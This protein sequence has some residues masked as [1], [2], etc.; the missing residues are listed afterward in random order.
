MDN[1]EGTLSLTE[2]G[3]VDVLVRHPNFRIFAAMN[4]ATDVGKRDLTPALHHRFTEI[5]VDELRAESDLQLVCQK[6]LDGMEGV[7]IAKIVEFY[8]KAKD[9]ALKD[10]MDGAGRSPHYS[11][12][13]LY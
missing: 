3:D 4:P 11:L 8:L 6:Y 10:L 12:R 1:P 7:P 13:T 5:Y 2:K 9:W